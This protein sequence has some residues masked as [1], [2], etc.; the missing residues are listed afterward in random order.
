MVDS[1][2]IAGYLGAEKIVTAPQ[3]TTD[4]RNYIEVSSV[5]RR[6]RR[7]K[8]V[9]AL[10]KAELQEYVV[11]ETFRGDDF[12]HCV[13]LGARCTK[14]FWK[15]VRGFR[16]NKRKSSKYKFSISFYEIK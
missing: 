15:R 8:R 3:Q 7:K 12:F 5:S 11:I 4:G 2:K 16:I 10:E 9:Y 6:K 1:R 14:D 13:Y